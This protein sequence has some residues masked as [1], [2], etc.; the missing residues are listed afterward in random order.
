MTD[1][2]FIGLNM[3]YQTA[4]GPVRTPRFRCPLPRR[5]AGQKRRHR[6]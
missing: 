6:R 2:M 4:G 5:H 3:H 1:D